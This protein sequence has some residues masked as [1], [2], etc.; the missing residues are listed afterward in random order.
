[1]RIE[2]RPGYQSFL[3]FDGSSV[4]SS[5]TKD[6]L[7]ILSCIPGIASI[8]L[9]FAS[10]LSRF[11]LVTSRVKLVIIKLPMYFF[12]RMQFPMLIIPVL[13][14]LGMLTRATRGVRNQAKEMINNLQIIQCALRHSMDPTMNSEFALFFTSRMTDRRRWKFGRRVEAHHLCNKEDS[15]VRLLFPHADIKFYQA[16]NIG[17]IRLCTRCYSSAKIADDSNIIFRLNDNETFGRIR[18]ILTV[19][20]GEPLLFVVHLSRVSPLA[21]SIDEF[22]NF[23]Y[24]RIQVSSDMNWSYVLIE[25]KDFVEKSVLYES[26]NG[27]CFFFR[28]PNLTHCS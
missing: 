20:G 12:V 1:M 10:A 8:I 25:A 14:F 17:H 13:T 23:T 16:L 27:H 18:S 24:T 9:W 4:I 11:H 21:C 28:F 6:I 19:D 7:E 5:D 26:L 22:E 15:A 2:K 3:S